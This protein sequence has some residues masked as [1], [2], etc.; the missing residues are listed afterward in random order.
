MISVCFN[1]KVDLHKTCNVY[2]LKWILNEVFV[3]ISKIISNSAVE[4]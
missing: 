4:L 2:C 3:L 1:K